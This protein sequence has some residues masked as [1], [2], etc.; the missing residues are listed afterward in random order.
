VQY[1]LLA[2]CKDDVLRNLDSKWSHATDED[3][4]LGLLGDRLDSHGSDV[5]AP[6]V[7]DLFVINVDRTCLL[8][9]GVVVAHIDLVECLLEVLGHFV[10]LALL[11]DT[12]YLRLTF[13]FDPVDFAVVGDSA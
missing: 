4:A 8:A 7:L 1:E 10:S 12:C 9:S 13:S 11:L 5:A 2:A 3:S 6:P